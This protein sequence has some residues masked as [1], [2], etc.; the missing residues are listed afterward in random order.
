ML[1]MKN[2]APRGVVSDHTYGSTLADIDI[3]LKLIREKT[4]KR[5]AASG[6]ELNPTGY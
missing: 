6:E 4:M 2:P 3:I 1:R 5:D